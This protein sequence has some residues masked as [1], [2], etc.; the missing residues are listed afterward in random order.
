MQ[1]IAEGSALERGA[2]AER[3]WQSCRDADERGEDGAGELL[4]LAADVARHGLVGGEAELS[5]RARTAVRLLEHGRAEAARDVVRHELDRQPFLTSLGGGRAYVWL[6]GFRDPRVDVPDDVYDMTDRVVLR[7]GLDEVRWQD[8][9]LVVAGFAHLSHL[10][11]EPDDAVVLVLRAR[12]GA[13]VARVPAER[14]RRPDRVGTGGQGLTRL[15]WSGFRAEVDPGA[16]AGS[17]AWSADVEVSQS[18][19]TRARRLRPAPGSPVAD[20][21][22]FDLPDGR[23]LRVRVGAGGRLSI[24]PRRPVP[25]PVRAARWLLRRV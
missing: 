25:L 18:G 9:R 15:A 23:S 2:V 14:V 24:T 5:I 12:D 4:A 21:L 16:L 19:L 3:L 10:V 8:G 22:P 13:V 17:S 6:P 1:A 7:R 11:A 20:L